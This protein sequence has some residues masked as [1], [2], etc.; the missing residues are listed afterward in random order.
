MYPNKYGRSS[1]FW[2]TIYKNQQQGTPAMNEEDKTDTGYAD[3]IPPAPLQE[4]DPIVP[5][6][7]ARSAA[8]ELEKVEKQMSKFEKST[9]RWARTAVI[10]SG[11][12]ALFVCFQ[13]VVMKQTLKEMQTSGNTSTNQLWQAIGNMNWMARTAD[14]ALQQAQESTNANKAQSLKSLNATI[15]QSRLEQRAWI[16][17]DNWVLEKFAVGAPVVLKVRVMNRGRTPAV[18]VRRGG[19]GGRIVSNDH[20]PA[21]VANILKEDFGKITLVP[22]AAIS[23]QNGAEFIGTEAVS[24]DASRF[25]ESLHKSAIRMVVE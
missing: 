2:G 8:Q 19:T 13:W 1:C 3:P 14:G 10:M 6:P 25:K 11:L 22:T 24:L 4:P 12:A 7:E 23:P 9:L 16:G 18:D 15:E 20:T 21:Q 5:R 17:I